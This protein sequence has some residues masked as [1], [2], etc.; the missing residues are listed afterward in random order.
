MRTTN[1]LSSLCA[2]CDV[3]IEHQRQETWKVEAV[4]IDCV[5][6]TSEMIPFSRLAEKVASVLHDAPP[7][8]VRDRNRR[9]GAT[10]LGSWSAEEEAMEP[11]QVLAQRCRSAT[12]ERAVENVAEEIVNGGHIVNESHRPGLV[13]IDVTLIKRRVQI[14]VHTEVVRSVT[15]RRVHEVASHHDH[16]ALVQKQQLG[17]GP[18]RDN[19]V[20]S[21]SV[22][23]G[24][25][26]R[27]H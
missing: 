16:V 22:D 9:L 14:P 11:M 19:T 20:P 4:L 10:C 17:V 26:L 18:K 2:L 25:V 23:H 7:S 21:V 1:E 12:D 5:H 13:L 8:S 6:D 24:I 3:P 15:R 27:C